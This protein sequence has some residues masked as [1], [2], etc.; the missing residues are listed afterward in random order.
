MDNLTPNS[1]SLS[2]LPSVLQHGLP[3][4]ATLGILSFL[5]S[6]ALF[7]MLLYRM[8][9]WHIKSRSGPSQFVF[10]I[11]N[12]VLADIQQSLAFL[13]NVEWLGRGGITV[14]TNSCW[15]QGWFVS[16]G[17]LASGVFC[18]A[19]GVHTFASLVWNY[20]VPGALFY[21]ACAG[22]WVFVYAL[23]IV[24]VALHPGDIYVRAGAWVSLPLKHSKQQSRRRRSGLRLLTS[25]QCWINESYPDL[26]LYTHY[27][28]IFICEFGVIVIYTLLYTIL[29][30]RATL[31]R[32]SK[33]STTASV[34]TSHSSEA[35]RTLTAAKLMVLYPLVYVLCTLPLASARMASMAGK[36]VPLGVLCMA[37]AMITS[38]GWLDALLYVSTRKVM[39]FSDAPPPEDAGID[40]FASP[41]WGAES[42]FGTTTTITA[43]RKRSSG[44]RQGLSRLG[45]GPHSRQGSM[46]E[47]VDYELSAEGV[48][49]N[50]IVQVRS[51]PMELQDIVEAKEIRR[52]QKG[53][54]LGSSGY[55]DSKSGSSLQF[56]TGDG[57]G[58]F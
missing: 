13:L 4:V 45:S 22:L 46:D 32:L 43:A 31:L 35:A 58:E 37:G 33:D 36:S 7:L 9:R 34:H 5:S 24:G 47:L 1:Q 6:S 41:F 49:K 57:K 19:I 48:M 3:A 50:T 51:E 10:L 30:R 44:T 20:R 15:A 18:L 56:K 11:F 23:A 2:P 29:I 14:G 21:S 39:I 25:N 52:K 38:N 16:T 54:D 53:G 28:F 12:L 27:I 42:R 55:D 26:R 17:D 8:Y 40:T